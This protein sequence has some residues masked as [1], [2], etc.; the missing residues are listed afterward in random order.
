MKTKRTFRNCWGFFP[1]ILGDGRVVDIHGKVLWTP[2]P[3]EPALTAQERR[4]KYPNIVVTEKP[5]IPGG[6]LT[7]WRNGQWISRKEAFQPQRSAPTVYEPL[8][9]AA[10][11]AIALAAL[12]IALF[13][14]PGLA[15]GIAAVAIGLV[16]LLA[17]PG[18][19]AVAAVSAVPTGTLILILLIWWMLE[20]KKRD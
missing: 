1:D 15:S 3:P 17:L 12:G 5:Y 11:C 10:F 9:T 8:W 20:D 4:R 16:A 18:F 19:V 7:Y 14:I 6:P 13:I 2:P